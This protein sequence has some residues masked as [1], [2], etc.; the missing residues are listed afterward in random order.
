MGIV[1]AIYAVTLEP[2]KYGE[3]IDSW[4]K[5]ILPSIETVQDGVAFEHPDFRPE[6]LSH[7]QLE[8]VRQHFGRA[9]RI[10]EK[11]GRS[12]TSTKTQ[13]EIVSSD[14][15]PSF[16]CNVN[17]DV[18]F[19]N[20]PALDA[21]GMAEGSKIADLPFHAGADRDFGLMLK[22]AANKRQIATIDEK[23]GPEMLCLISVISKSNGKMLLLAVSRLGETSSAKNAVARIHTVE[24]RWNKTLELWVQ[25][26]F[27]LSNAESQVLSGIMQGDTTEAI[28]SAR[29]RS[30]ATVRTQLKSILGK[31]GAGSQVN[32]IRMLASFKSLDLKASDVDQIVRPFNR[33]SNFV[34]MPDGRRLEYCTFGPT[35]GRPVVF[36]HSMMDGF[37]VAPLIEEDFRRRN[38]R[39]ITPWRPCFSGSDPIADHKTAPQQFAKDLGHLLDHLNCKEVTLVGHLG[40]A[41]YAFAA[42][43]CLKER[44]QSIVSVSGGVPIVSVDQFKQMA[45]RQRVIA[46]TARFMPHL[47]PFLLHAGVSQIDQG[48][49]LPFMQALVANSP[50]DQAIVNDE[51]IFSLMADGYRK[52]VAQGGRGFEIDAYHVTRDWTELAVACS[53]PK[54]VIHTAHDSVVTMNSV[55]KFAAS[56]EQCELYE[57]DDAGQ[58]IFYQEPSRVLDHIE[59]IVD[60]FG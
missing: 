10:F 7:Q 28:S 3:L 54:M 49:V 6:S 53:Q 32:L 8:E 55:R 40:G 17:G 24:T 51:R 1:D 48:G 5:E 59:D 47:L 57:Y 27:D 29:N 16:L 13:E 41:L 45:P 39:F 30:L 38:L 56:Q 44:V 58:F 35:S 15:L 43:A 60:R 46:Y 37:A 22:L 34:S 20:D 52:S 33:V 36:L 26:V 50:K 18:T 14:A 19:A 9:E 21:L 25:K 42:G 2:E 11:L 31:T 23:N 4:G 12:T